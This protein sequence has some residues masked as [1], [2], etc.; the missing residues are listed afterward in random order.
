M[1]RSLTALVVSALFLAGTASA[2]VPASAE[3]TVPLPAA[4]F[5]MHVPLIAAGD[6]ATVS[7]GAVRLWDSGVSWPQVQQAK[8]AFWWDGLDHAIQNAN[9]QGLQIMYVLDR[10]STR[11]NSSH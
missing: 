5:G 11:L 9:T 6:S 2:A 10:K 1:R 3:T 8:G 7:D 4:A